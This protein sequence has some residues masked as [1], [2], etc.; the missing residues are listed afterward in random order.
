V[1][2]QL[3][4]AKIHPS[5]LTHT[6]NDTSDSHGKFATE[7]NE[8]IFHSHLSLSRHTQNGMEI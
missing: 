1:G 8:E 2:A 3:D 7:E 4:G 5:P 6:N